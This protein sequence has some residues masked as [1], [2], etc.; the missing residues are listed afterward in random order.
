MVCAVVFAGRGGP[1]KAL[2]ELPLW[3]PLARLVFATYLVHPMT[4]QV[5]IAS[6]G[7]APAHF[8]LVYLFY[9]FVGY[10][11][12]SGL[13]AFLFYMWVE[14]PFGELERLLFHRPSSRAGGS[15]SG[16]KEGTEAAEV[17]KPAS[18]VVVPVQLTE[19]GEGSGSAAAAVAQ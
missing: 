13:A 16:K 4:I 19:A 9:Q 15:K 1:L 10:S 8:S 14:G 3:S 12:V 17:E 7:G 18:V 5:V 11:A 6:R 2:L